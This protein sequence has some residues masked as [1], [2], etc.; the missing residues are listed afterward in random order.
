MRHRA[1]DLL[2]GGHGADAHVAAGE[3][4]AFGGDDVQALG[5]GVDPVGDLVEGQA[6]GGVQA[7][8]PG[9]L[10]QVAGGE[11][12]LPHE[13]VH[14]RGEEDGAGGVPGTPDAGQ[15]VV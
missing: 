13:R 9:E 1:D 11:R 3:A 14:G 4:T 7:G 2:D 15:A 5:V 12:V 10:A 8:I 6:G